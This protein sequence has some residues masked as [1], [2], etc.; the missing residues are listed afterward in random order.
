MLNGSA[1]NWNWGGL[2]LGRLNEF[3]KGLG[4]IYAQFFEIV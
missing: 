1:K 2:F 3:P 4:G